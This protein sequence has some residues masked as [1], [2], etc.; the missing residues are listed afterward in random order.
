MCSHEFPSY[1]LPIRWQIGNLPLPAGGFFPSVVTAELGALGAVWSC[2]GMVEG[3][4]SD[5]LIQLMGKSSIIFIMNIHIY[6]YT[7]IYLHIYIC[8]YIY[9]YIYIYIHVYIYTCIYLHLY[10]YI[11]IYIH[12]YIY[13]YIYIYIHVYNIF[14][15]TLYI[16]IYT[17]IYIVSG[18]IWIL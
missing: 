12:I 6:I 18:I 15:Y 13:M 11:C 5:L 14:I 16:Y 1:R 17:Y 7:C 3:S 10:I 4:A 2:L 9:I 8:V